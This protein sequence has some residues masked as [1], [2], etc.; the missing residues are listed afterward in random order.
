MSVC[1]RGGRLVPELSTATPPFGRLLLLEAAGATAGSAQTKA[2][3]VVEEDSRS[4]ERRARRSA[5]ETDE[6]WPA[7]DDTMAE[8]NKGESDSHV[9][10]GAFGGGW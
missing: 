9:S 8:A 2:M 4:G 10:A 1:R 6:P 5:R 3:E 7:V